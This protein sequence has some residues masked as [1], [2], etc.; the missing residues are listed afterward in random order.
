MPDTGLWT[1]LHR[2]PVD[3][4]SVENECQLAAAQSPEAGSGVLGEQG[5]QRR[6]PLVTKNLSHGFVWKDS[7]H[8]LK[9]TL[10]AP[11]RSSPLERGRFHQAGG[12]ELNQNP[13]LCQQRN[14]AHTRSILPSG[15]SAMPPAIRGNRRR[16]AVCLLRPAME[17]SANASSPR[18][19]SWT[20]ATIWSRSA[21]GGRSLRMSIQRSRISASSLGRS[22]RNGVLNGLLCSEGLALFG[23]RA[24]TDVEMLRGE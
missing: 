3:P 13:R 1:D 2:T 9:P 20:V 14:Q 21:S 23:F 10:L 5:K 22:A 17:A 15:V 12:I 18:K 6:K 7:V 8:S 19:R 16:A 24:Q 4:S 11:D